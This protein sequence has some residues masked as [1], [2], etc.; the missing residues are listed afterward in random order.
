[1]QSIKQATD[2]ANPLQHVVGRSLYNNDVGGV[3]EHNR[4]KL[5]VCVGIVWRRENTPRAGPRCTELNVVILEIF[6]KAVINSR[7]LV[8]Q[9]CGYHGA[10]EEIWAVL[11]DLSVANSGLFGDFLNTEIVLPKDLMV[12]V[13]DH[14]HGSKVLDLLA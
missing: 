12:V 1:M 9:L 7:D 2:I 4:R 11:V 8:L 14:V 10:E 5:V 3:L 13:N 6:A